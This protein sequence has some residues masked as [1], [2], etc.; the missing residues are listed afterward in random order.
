[1]RVRHTD[2]RLCFSPCPHGTFEPMIV[3]TGG[4]GFIGSAVV[5]YLNALGETDIV[6]VDN[7]EESTKW[8]N[9]VSLKY[10]D[11]VHKSHFLSALRT[12]AFASVSAIIHM[13]ACSATTELQGDYLMANNYAYTRFIAEH[14]LEKGIRFVYASSA[15][16][17]GGIES[18]FN[19]D[20]ATSMTLKPINRY[21]Y[22]KQIFDEVAIQN[23]WQK[24]IAGIKFFNVYGPN[25][26]HKGDMSSVVYKA[27]HQISQTG[28]LKLFK[29]NRPEFGDGDQKRDFVY[30]KDCVDVISQLVTKRSANGIFNLGSGVARS[31]N[32]LAGAVFTAL[33]K[34]K[35]IEYIDMPASLKGSYQYFTEANVSRLADAGILLK[36]TSLEDGVLDYVTNYL[37]PGELR[38]QDVR[39]A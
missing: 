28:S 6:I 22:S 3:V 35:N 11:F 2:K 25:E 9:L 26:Y 38:L 37:K 33:G 13:G 21:G 10:R 23:G 18:G 15:A 19:D 36:K 14:A 34:E 7:L 31:W 39:Q 4:A 27:F 20:D 1:M 32:D 5:A 30:I 24:H 16:T 12:P 8:K 29:S 17:Y